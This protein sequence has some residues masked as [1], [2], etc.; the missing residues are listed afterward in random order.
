MSPRSFRVL[1][2]AARPSAGAGDHVGLVLREA[3]LNGGHELGQVATALRI[4]H[5]YLAA[6]EDGRFDALPGPTYAVGFVRSYAEY[7]GLRPDVLVERF[8]A[9]VDGVRA[10]QALDFPTPMPEGR[11]PGGAMLTVGAIL[12]AAVFGGWYYLD[13]HGRLTY[14]R[15]P[16]LPAATAAAPVK[17]A[18]PFVAAIPPRGPAPVTPAAAP[19]ATAVT[20]AVAAVVPVD[21][22]RVVTEAP[23]VRDPATPLVVPPSRPEAAA[24][25]EDEPVPAAGPVAETIP[26]EAADADAAEVDAGATSPTPAMAATNAIPSPAPPVETVTAAAPVQ[27]PVARPLPVVPVTDP[28]ATAPS[29]AAAA[30]PAATPPAAPIQQAAVPPPP[31]APGPVGEAGRVLGRVNHDARIVLNATADSWVQVR[32]GAQ[33]V[34]FTQML[35]AGDSYRVPN[36]EDLVLLTGNAGGLIIAVDGSPVPMLGP[37]GAVLRNVRLDAGA[38]KAGTATR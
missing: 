8:K 37:E 1:D 2:D 9:E 6:I 26:P 31:Q 21:N 32:D 24:G 25:E 15:I 3:R 22:G 14:P 12:A 19:P 5:A 27:E 20:S 35:R 11:F 10:R 13:Q 38:L 23:P 16:Q 36:R 18:T 29:G 17:P 34:L 33:N 30:P 28:A 4:R 7:L